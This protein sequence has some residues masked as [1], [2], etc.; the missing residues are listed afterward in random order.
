MDGH[1]FGRDSGGPGAQERLP[2]VPAQGSQDLARQVPADQT[3][4][5]QR[6]QPPRGPAMMRDVRRCMH[7]PRKENCKAQ[8]RHERFLRT[9]FYQ[10]LQ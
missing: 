8:E 1:A 9:R 4:E 10:P 2:S 6:R 3:F 5:L 7:L